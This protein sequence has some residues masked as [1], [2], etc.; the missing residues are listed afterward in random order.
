MKEIALQIALKTKEQ[1]LNILRE[2]LH[3]YILFLMQKV[4]MSSSLY[5]VGG[6]ALR[7]LY[8]TRRYSEDLDFSAGKDWSPPDFSGHIK[9]IKS[10]LE[11]AGYSCTFQIKEE[12]TIQ[13]A[14]VR[15]SELL[16][17]VG[18]TRQ[19]NKKFPIHIEIDINPPAGWE[20]KKTIVD[21]H[22]PVLLQHYDLPSMFGA[23]LAA[24]LTRPY[25]KGRDVYDIFWFR[26]KWKEMSP[27]FI[28]LNNAIAQK[29]SDFVRLNENNWL[30]IVHE[31][32]RSLKWETVVND[33]RPFLEIK[34]DLLTFTQENLLLLLFR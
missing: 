28:L 13:R 27:N 30:E 19:K 2:Y 31:K 3:N 10:D 15:F 5:F 1:K 32:I 26:S 22:L 20:G 29:Q 6:T 33:V 21:I 23:K 24:V 25:T 17:E 12:K 9:K 8:R 16:Y 7:F 18:L 11:K 4:R 14:M 34:D